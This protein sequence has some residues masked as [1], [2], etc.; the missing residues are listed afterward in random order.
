MAHPLVQPHHG[1]PT[2]TLF[3]KCYHCYKITYDLPAAKEAI[4]NDSEK[5][6]VG[7]TVISKNFG[8]NP[9]QLKMAASFTLPCLKI[10]K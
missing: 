3:A 6:S 2:N 7:G 1:T 4:L 9:M 5:T 10:Y 8:T